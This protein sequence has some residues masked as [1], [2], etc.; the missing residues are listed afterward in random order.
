MR[1][2][3]IVVFS[4]GATL[5]FSSPLASFAEDSSALP[6]IQEEMQAPDDVSDNL[7]LPLDEGAP[8]P[9]IDDNPSSPAATSSPEAPASPGWNLTGDGWE[10]RRRDGSRVE[11][12]WLGLGGSWYYFGGDGVA[13]TGRA[14]VG[15]APYYFGPDCRM[16][17][18][19]ARD[20]STGAWYHAGPSGRLSSG[21]VRLKGLWYWL[22]PETNAMA[23]DTW[24]RIDNN[25][26][27]FNSNGA[28]LANAWFED[29][30]GWHYLD[31]N[32]AAR[33]GKFTYKSDLYY[34]NAND[35]ANHHPALT[36]LQT[37]DGKLCFFDQTN[38]QMLTSTWVKLPNGSLGFA[39]KTGV[40]GTER[41]KDG[42]LFLN[43]TI[44]ASGLV[45][46]GADTFYADPATGKLLTGWQTIAGK[47]YWFDPQSMV[48]HHG[49]LQNDGN[50]YWF[51]ETSGVMKTGWLKTGNKWYWLDT[52][53]KMLID[54]QLISGDWYY[55]TPS[56]GAMYTGVLYWN[57]RYYLLSDSGKMVSLK[58][59]NMPMFQKA[60][61]YKSSTSW[62]IM[63]DTKGCRVGIYQGRYNAWKPIKEWSCCSGAPSTPTV[64][65]QFTVTGK[66]YSFGNGYTCYYYT[67]FYGD[68]LFH[69]ILYRPGTF[70]VQDGR[71][72][73]RISH[74]CIRLSIDN[75][76]W[77][78]NNIPYGTKV[79]TY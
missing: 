36:G 9:A 63:V 50:W 54:W 58:V 26:Y 19:W 11:S 20:P 56:T 52:D 25:S 15:G 40:I 72:G 47:T 14:V 5:V 67:Q 37:I 66:G 6:V 62:L 53:G 70:R 42:V 68:Y 8:D 77:I 16:A 57:G 76:K 44:R 48:M 17:V 59:S 73:V 21:W 28:M 39:S 22:D 46:I 61:Q 69:S 60:Q 29:G 23:S 4:I 71:M 3:T 38:A 34:F 2:R 13:L 32:G 10:Y 45:S 12:S 1:A 64:L 41:L 55:F 18:G 75:A 24:K 79:V 31:S 49:W 74:G 27:R 35:S 33:K 65:G 51:D 7:M 30:A 43:D 78:Y